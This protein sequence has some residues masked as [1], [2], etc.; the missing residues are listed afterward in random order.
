MPFE[1]PKVVVV[2]AGAMGGLFGGL[3]AEG[4]LD[5]T[6]VDAWPEHIAAIKADGLRI[7]G[8]G[9]DR[10]IKIKATTDASRGQ[11]RRRRAVPVQGVRQRGRGAQREASVRRRDCR[12]HV[13]ERA[14]QRAD[15]RRHSRREQRDRRPDRA[16]GP[17]RRPGVVRNFGDL[18]TYIG[19]MAGGLS[20]RAR[21]DRRGVHRAWAAD[22]GE[23]RD[24]AREVEEAARQCRARRDLGGHRSA[25]G[26]DHARAGAAGDRVPRG[27]RGGGGRQG[28]KASRSMSRRRARC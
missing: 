13:P 9:G 24:Q 19:E 5:V 18:P 6:L 3:L 10:D 16:G 12:D 8:V 4:G 26:R 1:N 11:E 15:A 17:R 22:Q 25:L 21:R 28:R 14:R 20:E 7:V 27:R 23:R 2:G